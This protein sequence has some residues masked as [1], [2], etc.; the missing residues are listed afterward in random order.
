MQDRGRETGNA[1]LTP[2][3]RDDDRRTNGKN[4][5]LNTQD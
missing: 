1:Q 4:S 3:R 2:E 5:G